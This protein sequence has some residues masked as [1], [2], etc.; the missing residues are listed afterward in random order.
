MNTKKY[1][2]LIVA[3]LLVL[4]ITVL[5][6]TKQLYVNEV[7]TLNLDVDQTSISIAPRI[8]GEEKGRI[9]ILQSQNNS[10]IEIAPQSEDTGDSLFLNDYITREADYTAESIIRDS[11]I[12]IDAR[13][14]KETN[15]IYI[16][17]IHDKT[18]LSGGDLYSTSYYLAKYALEQKILK[19]EIEFQE[20][21][22]VDITNSDIFLYYT[23][24]EVNDIYKLEEIE[25]TFDIVKV[26][27]GTENEICR[28]YSDI[29]L[30]C[31]SSQNANELYATSL[32]KSKEEPTK[33]FSCPETFCEK[34]MGVIGSNILLY[35]KSKVHLVTDK[36]KYS[37]DLQLSNPDFG[38]PNTS[39]SNDK[40]YLF[41]DRKDGIYI[42]YEV[43][44]QSLL[45][46]ILNL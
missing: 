12:V 24:R 30:V 39:Y 16:F 41:L 13:V 19:A 40:K 15:S 43:K 14:D 25:T 20:N 22:F 33:I 4:S 44:W 8:I 18:D 46:R 2:I 9:Y 5:S 45:S 6:L 28:L 10:I 32:S 42:I 1:L 29:D 17:Y 23:N 37:L 3:I 34:L 21:V 26:F 38:T 7:K 11:I 36:K 35:D 31:K 27:A